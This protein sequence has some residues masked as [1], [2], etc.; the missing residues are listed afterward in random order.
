MISPAGEPLILGV[1]ESQARARL[2]LLETHL[3]S[4]FEP[5]GSEAEVVPENAPAIEGA[6][7]RVH[8]LREMM[9]DMMMP[10]REN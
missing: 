1:P 9:D 6:R 2:L 10:P 7:A 5:K 4:L 3:R 8:A